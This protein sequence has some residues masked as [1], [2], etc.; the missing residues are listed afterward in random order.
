[1]SGV[2]LCLIIV[3]VVFVVGVVL[4]TI[5]SIETDKTI[6]KLNAD[7]IRPFGKYIGGLPDANKTADIMDCVIT[8]TGSNDSVIFLNEFGQAIGGI[9]VIL[10]NQIS[11]NDPYLIIDWTHEIVQ[12]RT[13]FQFSRNQAAGAANLLLRYIQA[14]RG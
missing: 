4:V 2:T 7:R 13:I 9:P 14:R 5:S 1:M 10:I 11:V 12:Y 6:K 3:G 8:N